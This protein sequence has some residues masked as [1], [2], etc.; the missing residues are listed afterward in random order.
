[1]QKL[2]ILLLIIIP[3]LLFN[4]CSK[5]SEETILM[6]AKTKMEEAKKFEADNKPED[7]KKGYT[8]AVEIYKKFLAEYPASPK[9]PEVYSNIAK[10]YVDNLRDY[11]SAIKYYEELSQKFPNTKES[12][13][14]M[15][16]VAFIYDEMLKDKDKAKENY[17]KFLDKYP[18][19]EDAN[20]KMSESARMM[21][22]MLEENRSI[23]DIIKNTQKDTVK[24]EIPEKNKINP[25]E[26]IDKRPENPKDK[27]G[28]PPPVN[29]NQNTKSN[30]DGTVPEKKPNQ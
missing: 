10:I 27:K 21:L 16:M 14:G 20:E 15:F 22:Q 26:E 1:M 6:N 5:E 9:A 18:K 23:E 24:K 4:S 12:K 29:N 3:A 2:R 30:D 19:D 28:N 13:Y 11:P 17:K 25:V 8:E 7:A